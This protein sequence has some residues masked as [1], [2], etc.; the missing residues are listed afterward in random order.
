MPSKFQNNGYISRVG[1]K[2][3][4]YDKRIVHDNVNG[5]INSNNPTNNQRM[6]TI[7]T[8]F[9]F[10]GVSSYVLGIL[11]NLNTIKSDILFFFGLIFI[12]AKLVRYSVRTWQA[13]KREEIEQEILR[14]KIED[15][16]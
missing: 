13:Y 12:V 16:E 14:K 4:S 11:L 1:S 9:S 5:F 15:D 8:I 6:E 7:I 3:S 2:S 10:L